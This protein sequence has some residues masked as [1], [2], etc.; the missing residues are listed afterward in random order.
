[1]PLPLRNKKYPLYNYIYQKRSDM[2][3]NTLDTNSMEGSSL[4]SL[5]GPAASEQIP[6]ISEPGDSLP[7]SQKPTTCPYPVLD[8]S[9][10]SLPNP[11]TQ[12]KFYYYASMDA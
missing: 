3:K 4:K 11:H 1:M 6:H 7:H 9:S 12:D 10:T 8:Q 5:M 2:G